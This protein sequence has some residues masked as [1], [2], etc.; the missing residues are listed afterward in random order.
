MSLLML[1]SKR[2]TMLSQLDHK[3]FGLES[4]KELYATILTSKMFIR[5]IEMGQYGINMCY[6]MVFCIV[7]KSFLFPLVPFVFCFYRK[8]MEV[9]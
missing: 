7:L 3:I 2:Y 6:I 1:L 9:V 8:R 4:M 5:I